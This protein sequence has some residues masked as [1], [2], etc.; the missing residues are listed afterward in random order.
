MNVILFSTKTTIMARERR[1]GRASAKPTM[2]SCPY[3]G[4]GCS[5][6]LPTL[7]T[8]ATLADPLIAGYARCH[9]RL[10]KGGFGSLKV[11]WER[12]K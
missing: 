3:R 11:G 12:N 8:Q 7:R 10:V 6:A 2:N 5:E 1:V 9:N 4:G